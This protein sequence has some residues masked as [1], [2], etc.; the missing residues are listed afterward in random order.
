M[1]FSR[2]FICFLLLYSADKTLQVLCTAVRIT[3]HWRSRR[4]RHLAL[5]D[6][7][8]IVAASLCGLGATI[9]ITT[10]VDS[11]LGKRDCLLSSSDIDQIQ[12]KVFVSTILFVFALSIS[13][14]SMI[15][16]LHRAAKTLIQ[17]VGI[18]LVGVI[19]LTWTLAVMTGIV[20]E[21]EMPRPWDIWAG[22]CI[23]MVPFWIT[24]TVVDIIVD[25]ALI[26]LAS[27]T[28][29]S[30]QLGYRQKTLATLIFCLRILL[31]VASVLRLIY[32][33]SAFTSI[34]DAT[35]KYIPYAIITQSQATICVVLSCTLTIQ[36]LVNILHAARCTPSPKP[37][38]HSEHWSGTT[39][40][41][42]R[43][44]SY[45]SLGSKSHLVQ[46]PLHAIQ[47]AMFTPTSN[48]ASHEDIILPEISLPQKRSAKAPPR[49]P[50]PS[51][52]ERPDLSMFHKITCLR[53]PPVV[54]KV[55]TR[56]W[57]TVGMKKNV[58]ESGSI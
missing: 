6:D 47:R 26:A 35:F 16:F 2:S 21:C 44:E 1:P 58:A 55:D 36:P 34:D 20:F 22:R 13:K 42:K 32:L 19:V 50:P 29:W 17:R 23:P 52:A 53:E 24:A 48:A 31:I 15:L 54:T 9:V 27:H 41:G 8:I 25:V 12:I 5:S 49:P 4:L 30:L 43:Y 56:T 51:D 40:G 46:E 28:V 57:E 18:I 11:G 37:R 39:I 14:C 7:A 45:E 33:Q 3:S 38:H 10:A